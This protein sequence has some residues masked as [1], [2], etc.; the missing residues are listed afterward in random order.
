[1]EEFGE[2]GIELWENWPEREKLKFRQALLK[3]Q[4]VNE[5]LTHEL[6]EE[7]LKSTFKF[8][9]Q[10]TVEDEEFHYLITQ[11]YAE[12]RRAGAVDN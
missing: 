5:E 1:M 4:R 3:S 8:L 12:Y 9:N 10:Y 7:V 11:I 2:H 6:I